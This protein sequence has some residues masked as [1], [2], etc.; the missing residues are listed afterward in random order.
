M[1]DGGKCCYFGLACIICRKTS[2]IVFSINV[3]NDAKRWL[4]VSV[5]AKLFNLNCSET[6]SLNDVLISILKVLFLFLVF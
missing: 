3:W 1:L 2:F 6:S 5:I 4:K